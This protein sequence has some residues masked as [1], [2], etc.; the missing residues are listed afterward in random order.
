MYTLPLQYIAT[1][2][3]YAIAKKTFFKTREDLTFPLW[4]ATIL[5]PR[6]EPHSKENT[7][8]ISAICT[9]RNAKKITIKSKEQ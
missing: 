3:R 9:L 1:S 6:K 2:G 7:T 4:K 8:N 5:L